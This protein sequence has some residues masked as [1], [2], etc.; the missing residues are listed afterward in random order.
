MNN[1]TYILM[2]NNILDIPTL[3]YHISAG[4]NISH[5]VLNKIIKDHHLTGFPYNPYIF[6][7]LIYFDTLLRY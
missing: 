1:D 7:S 6:A 3:S 5:F 4:Y 2:G